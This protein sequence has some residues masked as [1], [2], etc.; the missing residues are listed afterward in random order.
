MAD[1][2]KSEKATPRRKQEAR[3]RGQIVR[4]VEVNSV[5]VLLAAFT[6]F[7]LAGPYIIGS[8]N[9]MAV[10]SFQSMNT[11]LGMENVTTLA[12]FYLGQVL[13]I[14]APVL[15]SVLLVGLLV[16]YLQVGVLFTLKPLVPKFT[17]IN[18]ISGFQKIFSRR[19]AIEFLKSILKLI[20]IGWIAYAGVKSALPNLIP[21]MDMQG[22][23]P[24]KFVGNLA[25]DILDWIILAL[26]VLAVL[27]YLYQ[28][29]EYEQSLMM[30]KQEIKDEY[31]QSEGDPMI[32]ARIRQ[33]QREMARRRM[34][35][36]IPRADV[37]ITNPTHVAVALEY[38]DGMQAPVV[39]AKGERV[40]AERI[41]EMAR[42]HSIPIV[43]NPPLA[44]ALLKQCPV[45]AP[46][47]PD[48]FEAVAEVLAFVYRMNKKGPAVSATF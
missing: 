18:P 21:T 38:K 8:L 22:V 35:E 29:W 11:S 26:V 5:L 14:V 20:I 33:I 45:G 7:R 12:V 28:R 2:A 42:R 41:K 16:N 39:L 17:N 4:S 6:A 44:R 15:A 10:Y 13:K 47:S 30:T 34:F 27:D 3:E 37:V 24:L 9:D 36:S 48:L 19:S 40:I 32:K 23:E 1:P 31:K 43:E 25:V 46:I